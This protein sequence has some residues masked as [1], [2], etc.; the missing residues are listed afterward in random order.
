[1]DLRYRYVLDG[2]GAEHICQRVS[3]LN[4]YDS[5]FYESIQ[6][7]AQH[8]HVHTWRG[9]I[10]LVDTYTVYTFWRNIFRHDSYS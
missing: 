9:G 10:T 5:M 7:E 6:I 1:V 4:I 3:K 8:L 2:S